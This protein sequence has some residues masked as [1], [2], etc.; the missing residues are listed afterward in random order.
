MTFLTITIRYV[1]RQS[2]LTDWRIF[3]LLKLDSS[4]NLHH[5]LA[6]ERTAGIEVVAAGSLRTRGAQ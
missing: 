3:Y 5:F 6:R 2:S 1:K 4:G